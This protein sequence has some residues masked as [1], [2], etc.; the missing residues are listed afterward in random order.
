MKKF[1]A[2]TSALLACLGGM[3]QTGEPSQQKMITVYDQ[4]IFFDGYNTLENLSQMSKDMIP[5]DDILRHCTYLYGIRLSDEQLARI[6]EQLTMEVEIGA[7]CDNYDRIGNINLAFVPKG[8][9]TYHPDEVS[10]IEI[11]RFITPFMNKNYEPTMVPYTFPLEHVSLILRDSSLRENFD[12]W[13]EFEL[14]GVPYAANSQVVGCADRQDVFTATLRFS[15]SGPAPLTDRDVLVPIVIKKQF[16]NF[17]NYKEGCCDELGKTEKTWS[18]EVP[19]DVADAHLALVISN[20]GANSGGE[21]Y[22]RR[23]HFV[24]VDGEL[25]TVFTP[26]RSSCEPYRQYNTQPNGIYGWSSKSDAQWQSFS[27][28]CPGDKID[29]RILHLGAMT[30]GIHTVTI[31]VPDAKFKNNEGDFPV[32]IFFQGVTEGSLPDMSSVQEIH[33]N[34]RSCISVQGDICVI[35]S[36]EVPLELRLYDAAG[37]LLDLRTHSSEI[38]LA[39]IMHGLAL[40][41]VE[42]SDGLSE[43]HKIMR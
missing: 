18:F 23:E 8:A 35:D 12:I 28:W 33:P 1:I 34:F 13:A 31:K 30:Q 17:N 3:A 42:Y 11:G 19:C 41:V 22:N 6:G 20:H 5:D 38:S 14:F 27:N 32:S 9:D 40:V 24:Y 7:L 29:N 16:N 25:A 2:I 21:E 43:Y 4:V 26:G 10:R 15:A 37:H 39:P 36:A